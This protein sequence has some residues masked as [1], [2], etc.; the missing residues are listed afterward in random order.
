MFK[1]N[2]NAKG[3]FF[4]KKTLV[5]NLESHAPDDLVHFNSFLLSGHDCGLNNGPFLFPKVSKE[6]F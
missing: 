1:I 2:L 5:A 4:Q 3:C 6:T